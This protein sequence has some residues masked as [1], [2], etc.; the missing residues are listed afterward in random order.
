MFRCADQRN[1]A[2]AGDEVGRHRFPALAQCALGIRDQDIEQVPHALPVATV[3]DI[4]ANKILRFLLGLAA[5]DVGLA[6][7][8]HIPVM[9]L[10]SESPAISGNFTSSLHVL[11]DDEVKVGVGRCE[12]LAPGAITCAH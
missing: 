5:D 8:L 2:V 12:F 3:I 4:L 10:A 9:S 6:K 11:R 1:R 7:D